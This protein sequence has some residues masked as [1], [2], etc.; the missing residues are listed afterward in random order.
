MFTWWVWD[1]AWEVDPE[2][3]Q[4][5]EKVGQEA[6]LLECPLV[7]VRTSGVILHIKIGNKPYIFNNSQSEVTLRR[8]MVLAGHGRGKF[9]LQSGTEEPDTTK[10]VLYALNSSDDEVLFN[11]TI[12]TVKQLVADQRKQHP[13]VTLSYH[14]MQEAPS[15]GAPDAFTLTREHNVYFTPVGK[16]AASEA[17]EEV[18]GGAVLQTQVASLLPV[19]TWNS[20]CTRTLFV[21]KWAA[22]GLMPVRPQVALVQDVVLLPGRCVALF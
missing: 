6:K 5:I 7:N 20:H 4:E 15:N 9:K 18:A 21:V 19:Q 17:G 8:G 10:D 11:N 22:S 12:L 14:T 2:K 13:V 16:V 1:W 3:V